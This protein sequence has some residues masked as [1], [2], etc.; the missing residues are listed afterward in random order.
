MNQYN[1]FSILKSNYFLHLK[2]L[3][4]TLKLYKRNDV[5]YNYVIIIDDD[6]LQSYKNDLKIIEDE[7]F[8]LYFTSAKKYQNRIN[9]PMDSYIYYLRCLLPSICRGFDKILFLDTDILILKEGIEQLF[10]I[11]ISNYY[12]AGCWDPLNR[13]SHPES[14]QCKTNFYFNGGVIMLNI[15]KI[16]E[17]GKDKQLEQYLLNW[18]QNLTP[19]LRDQ[20]LLNYVL[21]NN[22]KHCSVIY[23]Q[24]LPVINKQNLGLYLYEC[25]NLGY[26]TIEESIN[27]TIVLHLAGVKIWNKIL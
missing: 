8:K 17:D 23:N 26:S 1:F 3:L 27:D 14:I 7:D 11:D 6:E 20:T 25:Q 15:N 13:V 12:G 19:G 16:V 10:K 9:P 21:R 4:L 5:I 22:V 24:I 2:Q 18:P